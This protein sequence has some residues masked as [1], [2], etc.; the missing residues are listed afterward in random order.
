MSS[1]HGDVP[2][3]CGLTAPQSSE[4]AWPRST[5]RAR[6][7][8]LTINSP[9]RNLQI[10][11]REPAMTSEEQNEVLT[12][13]GPALLSRFRVAAR[14]SVAVAVAAII[15]STTARPQTFDGPAKPRRVVSINLCVDEMVL[16]LADRQ[17]IASVTW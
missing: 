1:A 4:R 3:N 16:R 15:L 17:N 11:N 10:L 13:T 2:A 7:L 9:Y 12:R 14:C 5:P 8:L 6:S